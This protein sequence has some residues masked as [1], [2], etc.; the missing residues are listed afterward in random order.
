MIT[1]LGSCR[2]HPIKNVFKVNNIQEE[3][4]YSH[5]TKEILQTIYLCKKKLIFSNEIQLSTLRTPI[6]NKRPIH[7]EKVYNEYNNSKIIVIEIASS[8][9]HEL[10]INN[11]ILQ[12]H[13]AAYDCP[14]KYNIHPHI[15]SLIHLRKQTEEEIK[16][17][18]LKIYEEIKPKK[19]LIVTH[20][21]TDKTTS[22][23]K[24][25]QLVENTC[26]KL[27]I[28]VINPDILLQ[29]NK[30][31]ELF[32]NKANIDII[33]KPDIN[34]TYIA[35]YSKFGNSMIQNLYEKKIKEILSNNNLL[36]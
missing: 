32:E 12:C 4:N 16:S 15:K 36:D 31:E 26:N 11:N 18:I 24:L 20:F 35:H 34:Y 21:A 25:I 23:Y 7:F 19:L 8:K 2:Q 33:N 1:I 17:D 9:C 28:P 6:L 14:V 3:V 10:N 5:N 27:N 13:H 30:I 22:R 29:N